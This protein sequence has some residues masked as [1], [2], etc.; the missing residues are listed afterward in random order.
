LRLSFV[1]SEGL[2]DTSAVFIE[3]WRLASIHDGTVVNCATCSVAGAFLN[4]P[5]ADKLLQL[6]IDRLSRSADLISDNDLLEAT[7]SMRVCMATNEIENA[8]MPNVCSRITCE[9]PRDD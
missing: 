9:I 3:I 5:P 7:P 6:T 2:L 1:E 4:V 8:K